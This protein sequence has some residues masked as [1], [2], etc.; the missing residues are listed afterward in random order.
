MSIDDQL[1]SPASDVQGILTGKAAITHYSMTEPD[2]G[3]GCTLGVRG[4]AWASVDISIQQGGIQ[5]FKSLISLS[6]P[7]STPVAGIGDEAFRSSTTNSNM[8]N[9]KQTNLFAR[10]GALIC[11][12]QLHRSNGAGEKLVIPTTDD[13]I[14]AKLGTL[15]NKLFAARGRT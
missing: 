15:C 12:V 10:K 8:P 2:P 11:I 3:E 1:A 13:A 9:A 4:S 7:A 5:T 14:A 6:P